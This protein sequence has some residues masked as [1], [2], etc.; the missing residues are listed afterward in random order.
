VRVGNPCDLKG[1][2]QKQGESLRNYIQRFSRKCHKLPKIY[3]ADSISAFWSRMNC[4]TL[5]H[6]LSC[7]L[8]KT[9]KKLLDIATRHASSEE[10][11]R[12]IFIQ[13]D[14]KVAPI[15]GR[16][17]PL[18]ADDKGMKRSAKSDKRR[19]SGDP[20]ELQ[21]L[22]AVI[23]AAMTRRSMTPTRS[24]WSL[25]NATSNTR[26]SSPLITSRSFSKLPAPTMC[27]MLG[28]S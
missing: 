19:Q 4:R 14:R 13:G 21:S 3:D 9:T 5:V 10:A 18:K 7:N 16:G 26:R 6:E 20:N 8:L 12:A 28:I 1:C 15:G 27:T 17:V 2:W 23:R 25:V 24:S 11:A 22:P